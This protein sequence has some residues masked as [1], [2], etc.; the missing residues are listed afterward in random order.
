MVLNK[1]VLA[2]VGPAAL[3]EALVQVYRN[4]VFGCTAEVGSKVPYLTLC[5]VQ[6]AS[7]IGKNGGNFRCY[8][9]IIG[10]TSRVGR[11]TL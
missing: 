9:S 5:G 10:Y 8:R 1:A 4:G 3:G 7:K 11:T 6:G 2:D